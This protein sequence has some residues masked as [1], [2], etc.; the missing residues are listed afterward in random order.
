MVVV[1]LG[2]CACTRHDQVK[3]PAEPAPAQWHAERRYP[4]L[5]FSSKATLDCSIS[6]TAE[7]RQIMSTQSGQGFTFSVAMRPISESQVKLQGRGMMYK[8][9]A[10]PTSAFP[11]RFSG[12]GDGVVTAMKAEIEVQVDR[13][14]QPGGPGT[15][16]SFNASDISADAAYVEFTGIWVRTKDKKRFPFR[17]LFSSVN[18]GKGSVVPR[19]RAP[20]TSIASKVVMLGSPP[21]PATVT[22]SLY[23]EEDDVAELPAKTP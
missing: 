16:I 17:V 20:E 11:A 4:P 12:L 23:E 14:T 7:G 3:E 1:A 19:T 5:V 18:D 6:A 10:F 13:F 2:V 15:P 22:T 9:N 8:F 21:A